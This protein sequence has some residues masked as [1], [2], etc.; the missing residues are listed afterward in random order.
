M[1]DTITMTKEQLQE[2]MKEVLQ[3]LPNIQT[4]PAIMQGDTITLKEYGGDFMEQKRHSVSKTTHSKSAVL[5]RKHILPEFGEQTLASITR[6][7]VQSLINGMADQRY[8]M[9]TIKATKCLFSSIMEL[10][11]SDRL[12]PANPCKAV[13]LP[14]VEK[15]KKRAPTVEEYQRLLKASAGHRLWITVPLIFL[16]G[17]RIGEML[18]LTW[19]DIDMENRLIHVSKTWSTEN[20]SGRAYL[21]DTPKT[22]AGVRHIPI[23]DE[24]YT[25]LKRYREQQGKDKH[26]VIPKQDEDAYTHPQVFRGKIF[27]YWCYAADLPK[28][29]TPHSGRHYFAYHLYAAGVNPETLRHITGHSDIST[30]L[31]VYCHTDKL[32]DETLIQ[33]RTVMSALCG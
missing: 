23:C 11:A 22:K 19:D 29:I 1:S 25:M 18:A 12:I 16:T 17:M 4:T 2:A 28:D 24:L 9:E 13:K 32:S 30:L 31:D 15:R 27:K 26:I 33:T 3:G 6:V 7:Q 14:K 21:K 5:Y 20:G 10:A 8:S